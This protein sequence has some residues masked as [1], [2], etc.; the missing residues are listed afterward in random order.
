MLGEGGTGGRSTP[1]PL[2]PASGMSH[3][4][5]IF[6]RRVE[7]H[8]LGEGVRVAVGHGERVLV[9]RALAERGE[10]LA[11]GQPVD[12]HP[13]VEEDL[14]VGIE[15]GGGRGDG[16]S[17]RCERTEGV[18]GEFEKADLGRIRRGKGD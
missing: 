10:L 2:H 9:E 11:V 13:V 15:G 4:V 18:M 16:G 6:P 1:P 14:G 8:R 12:A 3:Q 17:R 7:E 5:E